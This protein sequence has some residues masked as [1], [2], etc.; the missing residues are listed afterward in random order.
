VPPSISRVDSHVV[1]GSVSFTVTAS[2]SGPASSNPAPG[3]AA[4]QVMYRDGAA[5]AYTPL[6]L[7][8]ANG[9]WTGTGPATSAAVEF[10]VQATDNS[11]NTAMTRNKAQNYS[12][13]PTQSGS[14]ST[15]DVHVNGATPTSARFYNTTPVTVDAATST[16]GALTYSVDGSAVTG[17]A[18][19]IAVHG[20]GFHTIRFAD[21]TSQATVEFGIDTSPPSASIATPHDGAILFIG[22]K[23]T[24]DYACTDGG[25]GLA[26]T[27]G[28]VGT[29]PNGASIPTLRLPGT[30][31]FKVTATDVYGHSSVATSSYVLVPGIAFLPP[32]LG[33]PVLN[34]AKAGSTI[35]VNFSLI[36]N[37]GL[38]IFDPGYPRSQ[39]VTCPTGLT[40]HTI[41]IP[42]SVTAGL[43][44][45]ARTTVYTYGW[46][47]DAS[48]VGTC[49]EFTTKFRYGSVR[50]IQVKFVK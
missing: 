16:S 38:N 9:V 29:L 50:K 8:F 32:A 48:W 47:T 11:G 20:D 35:P 41:D 36:S 26:A 28:C 10:F 31:T 14:S 40:S 4:V 27:G 37:L 12:A 23:Y 2:D 7:T 13:A 1:S 42:K 45:D 44:Y 21:G 3:V 15:I 19:P 30:Y 17:Y 24:A 33:G 43:T 25:A 5:F 18:G 34:V 39:Q 49:R 6:Y 22:D 46:K